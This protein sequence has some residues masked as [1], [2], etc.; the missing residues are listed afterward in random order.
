MA[1]LLEIRDL[2]AGYGGLP[3]LEGIDLVLDQGA[4]GVILGSNGAGKT[5]TLRSILNLAEVLGGSIE[6]DGES[7]AGQSTA[8][9][10]ER[11]VAMAPEG[12]QLFPSLTV[13]ENLVAGS[14]VGAGRGQRSR[15]MG[16]VF[17]YFPHLAERRR[18]TAG[19]LSGGEQQMLTIGRALMS[20]PRLLLVDE[21]SLGLAPIIVEALFELVSRINADG[22]TVLAVEQNIA[23]ID[24]ADAVLVLEKGRIEFGGRVEDVADRLRREVVAAYLGQ[25]A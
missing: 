18:Q 12:R 5:T 13:E 8:S 22:V 24:H 17:E 6:L 11:G 1:P 3:V 7:I 4:F 19:T 14:L 20:A 2:H 23:V 25:E 10:V 21:A 15:Q 16:Q 9:I